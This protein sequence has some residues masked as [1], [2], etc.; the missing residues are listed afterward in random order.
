MIRERERLGITEQ[1]A[2]MI[3]DGRYDVAIGILLSEDLRGF[4]PAMNYLGL[5]YQSGLGVERSLAKARRL[6][7]DAMA[8]G[9]GPAAHNLGTLTILE[10]EEATGELRRELHRLAKA[11]YQRAAALGFVVAGAEWYEE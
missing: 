9:Y 11:C 7:D 2:G 6:F 4:P 10:A 3:V 1:A 5:L 8:Q